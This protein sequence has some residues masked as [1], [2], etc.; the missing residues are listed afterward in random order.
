MLQ[1]EESVLPIVSLSPELSHLS[2]AA[3]NTEGYVVEFQRTVEKGAQ[4]R[5]VLTIQ[6]FKPENCSLGF[7]VVGLRSEQRGE[8]GIF[9]QEIQSSGIAGM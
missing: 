7:S 3:I 4:G 6:L 2:Q 8:L 5:D 9:V 1:A